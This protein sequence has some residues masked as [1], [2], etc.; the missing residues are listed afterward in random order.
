MSEL[1]ASCGHPVTVTIARGDE[2]PGAR[3]LGERGEQS[4]ADYLERRGWEVL[5]RNWRCGYGEAD[6]IAR[7]PERSGAPVVLVEVKTRSRRGAVPP[8]PEEA[9]DERKRARY[10]DM[11]LCY[12]RDHPDVDNVRFDVIAVVDEGSGRARLRH[13]VGAFGTTL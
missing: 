13:Y 2:A 12:L 3:A 9:V 6:I 7:D 10:R 5:E 4:A 11:A 8:L 1:Q